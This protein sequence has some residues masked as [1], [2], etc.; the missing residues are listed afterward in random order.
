MAKPI[1]PQ[2][3]IEAMMTMTTA[4]EPDAQAAAG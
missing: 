2:G 1:N 3:L 4:A